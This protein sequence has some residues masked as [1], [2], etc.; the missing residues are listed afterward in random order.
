MSCRAFFEALLDGQD[1]GARERLIDA[2]HP[3]ACCEAES[4]SEHSKRPV[5]AEE[6]LFRLVFT[7]IHEKCG[8]VLPV[9]FNDVEGKGL[10]CQRGPSIPPDQAVH[11]HGVALVQKYN[12]EHPEN[13][14]EKIRSYV[15][16]VLARCDAVRAILNEAGRRAFA[17]Y[18][19]A[20][21]QNPAHVD[22][23]HCGSLPPSKKK[24]LRKRLRDTFTP[25]LMKP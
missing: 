11:G 12:A 9:A 13:P 4:V 5:A 3:D 24:Q 18:D 20:L 16:V 23:F 22:V 7:P 2:A 15:G 1:V 21:P 6:F 10:S 19:T 8:K 17:V 14:P 25:G